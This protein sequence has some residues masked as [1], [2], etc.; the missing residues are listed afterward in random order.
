MTARVRADIAETVR[1]GLAAL[2]E[3]TAHYPEALPALA[4]QARQ[5]TAQTGD[6]HAEVHP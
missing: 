1:T 5:I 6:R 3:I 2:A 4:E